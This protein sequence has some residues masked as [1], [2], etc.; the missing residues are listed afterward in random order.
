MSHD[1]YFN[2]EVDFEALHRELVRFTQFLAENFEE[3][4]ETEVE[5][6][7]DKANAACNLIDFLEKVYDCTEE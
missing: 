7:A 2:T 5:M 4:D 1:K 6:I 3:A